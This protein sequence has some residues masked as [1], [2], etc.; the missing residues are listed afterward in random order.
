MHELLDVALIARLRPAALVVTSR[1]VLE[2]LDDLLQAAGVKAKDI[3]AL[4]ADD[5]DEGTLAPADQRNQRR[6]VEAPADLDHVWHALAQRQRPP[7]I[8]EI[9]EKTAKP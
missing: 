6:E 9:A 4:A 1:L 5:G 7:E 8:V 3:T 2:L